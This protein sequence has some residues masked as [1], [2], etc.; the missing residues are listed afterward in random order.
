MEMP[1]TV[2]E[3]GDKP[4]VASDR[5]L[6]PKVNQ[7]CFYSVAGVLQIL[8]YSWEGES[9]LFANVYQVHYSKHQVSLESIKI[10]ISIWRY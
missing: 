7:P 10:K 3:L 4:F 9:P 8:L 1:S 6:T 2:T 5:V